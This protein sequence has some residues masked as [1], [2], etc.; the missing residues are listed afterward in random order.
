MKID[1]VLK[2]V[3]EIEKFKTIERFNKTSNLKRAESDAEHSW[4]L[5]MMVYLFAG[6]RRINRQKV[7]EM[8]MVHDL[9]EI[10]AGDVNIWN[11]K[12]VTKEAKHKTEE[13]AARKLFNLLPGRE[14]RKLYLL[15]KEYE[16][17]ETKEAKFVYAL[18]KLQGLMQRVIS[19]DN[20][21]KEMKVTFEK[22]QQI[23]P[24]LVK[25]DRE[26]SELWD[27]LV[28]EGVREGLFWE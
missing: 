13:R 11:K 1:S 18:D 14:G 7:M 20:G 23:K 26:L 28:E 21:W 24:E 3:R 8:A 5:A 19:R 10:Y 16:E 15:W 25:S 27:M 17:R 22:H 12:G 2:F 4:H 6:M 9:V